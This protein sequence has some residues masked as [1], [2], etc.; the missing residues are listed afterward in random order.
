MN[1]SDEEDADIMNPRRL[2]GVVTVGVTTFATFDGDNVFGSSS[3]DDDDDDDN[4]ALPK[5]CIYTLTPLELN[6]LRSQ[7]H[8]S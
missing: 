2:A 4:T 7:A 6:T 5:K 8:L 3:S 1:A